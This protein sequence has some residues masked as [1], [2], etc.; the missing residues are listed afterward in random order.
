MTVPATAP[1]ALLNGTSTPAPAPAAP[2][3]PQ[4]LTAADARPFDAYRLMAQISDPTT[5]DQDKPRLLAAL[6]DI[7]PTSLVGRDQPAW[8]GQ[9]WQGVAYQRRITPLLTQKELTGLKVRG[10]R[11]VTKPAMAKYAG[12]KTDIPSSAVLTQEYNENAQRFA[13]GNDIDRAYADFRDTEFFEAL[14]TAYAE[15]YA[16]LTD[17]YAVEKMKA[18]ALALTTGANPN[19]LPIG[20]VAIVDGMLSM[21]DV[22]QPTFAIVEASVWR[23][24]VLTPQDKFLEFVQASIPNVDAGS[25]MSGF[26]IVP[27]AQANSG[28]ASTT[29]G[30]DKGEVLVGTSAAVTYRELGGGTPI[31]VSALDIAKGG[32][33]EAAFGYAH[34]DVTDNRGL[35]LVDTVT[36]V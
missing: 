3:E 36:D 19:S 2:A 27:V 28:T 17:A 31:R 24:M 4:R 16:K 34:V 11:W 14:H 25:L 1:A 29:L 10:W 32:V 30:L 7:T 20:W 12:G 9:L 15:S 22:G 18:A 33:D 35:R 23:D 13:G 21:L 5:P 26:R 8:V 6:A